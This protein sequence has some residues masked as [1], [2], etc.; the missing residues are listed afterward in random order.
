MKKLL[1]KI[2]I[3]YFFKSIFIPVDKKE[4]K[5]LKSNILKYL[6]FCLK[7]KK[8]KTIISSFPSSGWNYF[9]RVI[10]EYINIHFKTKNKKYFTAINILSSTIDISSE[11][12]N[13]HTH[14]CF[15]EI[16]FFAFG[17]INKNK[18]ILI[19]RNYTTTLYSYFKKY[20]RNYNFD[21]FIRDGKSL[22]RIVDY[23]NSW[24]EN[25][26]K[27]DKYLIIKYEE[28][29]DN[30][31]TNYQ[32]IITFIYNIKSNK[33]IL[34]TCVD[35]ENFKKIKNKKKDVFLGQ[36]NYSHLI[37]KNTMLYIKHYLNVNLT[38]KAKNTFKY[39]I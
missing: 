18:K 8:D 10:N 29:K 31:M 13:F 21:Q 11:K 5:I 38:K 37:E 35:N 20:N 17:N 34:R 39:K 25:I 15:F 19:T 26:D 6:V 27:I 36:D 9:N 32:K 22:E 7:N 4:N 14:L 24:S 33:K 2:S 16:P 30:P 28:L 3:L 12:I 1:R 23:Y